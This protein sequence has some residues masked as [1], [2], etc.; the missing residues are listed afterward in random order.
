M[1]M[2]R[3]YRVIWILLIALLPIA[4]AR[5]EVF[6]PAGY[7][8]PVHKGEIASWKH[9]VLPDADLNSN[10]EVFTEGVVKRQVGGRQV[11]SLLVHLSVTNKTNQELTFDGAQSHI[12][13]NRGRILNPGAVVVNGAQQFFSRIK[14]QSHVLI[15]VFYDIPKSIASRSIS[16]FTVHWRYSADKKPYTQSAVFE[17]GY[18]VD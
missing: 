14:P 12:L 16:N 2:R 1:K 11:P 17:K 9:G 10:F 8:W 13:D 4:C 15:D 6:K 5:Q 18:A 3:D 7:K